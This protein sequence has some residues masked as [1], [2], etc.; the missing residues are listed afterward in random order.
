MTTSSK[1]LK[2]V[3]G[4]AKILET[5]CR[6]DFCIPEWVIP[7]MFTLMRVRCGYGLSAPQVGID[8]RLFVTDWGEVFV[9]PTITQRSQRRISMDEECLSFPNVVTSMSRYVQIEMCGCRYYGRQAAVLQHELDHLNGL[10]IAMKRKTHEQST[11]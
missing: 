7:E 4:P 5:P 1:P 9:N 11:L 8:A 10:H 2:L 6:S 3:I